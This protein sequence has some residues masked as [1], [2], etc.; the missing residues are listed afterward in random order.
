MA[1]TD[2]DGQRLGDSVADKLGNRNLI[3]NGAMVHDQRNSGSEVTPSDGDYTLDRY[4]SGAS[5]ASKFKVQQVSDAPTGF[6]KSLKVTSLSAYSVGTNDNFEIFQY[7]EG[8]NTAYLEYGTSNAKTTTLS[9]YVKSS[10]TGTHG[11]VFTNSAFNRSYPFSYTISTA[12]TWE[13]KTITIPGDTSGT[14]IGSTNGIG[15]VVC[16]GLGAGSGRSGTAGAW[17]GA[18]NY[19]AT[20]AVSVVGTNAATWF[21]TGVQLEV[22]NTAT[23]FEHRSFGYELA[24][25]QRYCIKQGPITQ[26]AP[27]YSANARGAGGFIAFPTEMRDTPAVDLTDITYSGSNTLAAVTKTKYGFAANYVAAADNTTSVTFTYT[28]EKEL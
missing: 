22:G 25:C 7:I 11:G 13:Y 27:G 17:V 6:S 10:L 28:A 5:A 9:F 4:R 21:V 19:N 16:L 8:Y 26:Y 18:T 24:R 20:G 2:I 15:L 3:I 12:D 14:W 1:L 23:P